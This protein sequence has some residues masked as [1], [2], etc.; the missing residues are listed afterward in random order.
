MEKIL[1]ET[2][3]VCG[4]LLAGPRIDLGSHPLNDDMYRIGTVHSAQ[5]YR[6]EIQLCSHCFTAHQL[7]P[8]Q[9]EILF[10]PEY[11]YRG[12]VTKDV[13]SGMDDLID[14]AL[15]FYGTS[16]HLKV[17][18]IGANDGTLLGLVKGKINAETIGVDPTH[19]VLDAAGRIDYP[20]CEFFSKET[21]LKIISNHGIP[22]IITFTNVFAHIENLPSLI[23]AV[24]LLIDD[25]NLLVIENHYLGSVLEKNQFDTFYA[26]HIRTYSAKSFIHIAKQLN[27]EIKS[28]QFPKRYGGN[29]RVY[30]SRNPKYTNETSVITEDHF[31]HRFEGV[32]KTYDV[33]LK[34]ASENLDQILTDGPL[35]GKSCP[36]RSV[37]LY[38]SLKMDSGKMSSV[39]EHPNSPKIGFCVPGTQ[40]PIVSDLQLSSEKNQN[41]IL[42]SW[43]IAYE[44][45]P[46]LKEIGY[47]GNIW[48]PL[49]T[50]ELIAK[51]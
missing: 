33:W 15:R 20:Y 17:L 3:E 36:A 23:E 42:W 16:D 51:L 31:V 50:F 45:I 18:D 46:Y 30:L 47:R 43:H 6:Q 2:C 10:F 39:Y 5:R 8:V 32:Q 19:A 48:S 37:M 40:I 26:E 34:D 22:D 29:I 14:N 4:N 1:V 11:R 12:S 38:S 24:S 41:M 21:A 28:I 9:K 49:P 7:H 44:L 35:I 13:V 27:L 25:E